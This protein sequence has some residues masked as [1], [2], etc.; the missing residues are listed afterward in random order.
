MYWQI[1]TIACFISSAFWDDFLKSIEGV[2][3]YCMLDRCWS[4]FTIQSSSSISIPHFI[5]LLL[6]LKKKKQKKNFILKYN[7]DY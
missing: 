4:L 3:L 6:F 2:Q 1:K 5:L 7:S